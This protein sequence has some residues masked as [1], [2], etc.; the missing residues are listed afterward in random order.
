[1][2]QRLGQSSGRWSAGTDSSLDRTHCTRKAHTS[3]SV[4]TADTA[5]KVD[6]EDKRTAY[7]AAGTEAA[8]D[9]AAAEDMRIGT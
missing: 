4:D 1:M 7:L 9:T 6:T 2:V 8:A 3:P 5:G